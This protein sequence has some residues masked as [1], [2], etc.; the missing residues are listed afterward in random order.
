MMKAKRTVF[1][2]LTFTGVILFIFLIMQPLEILHFKDYIAILFPEGIIG[3][4]ERN[5]LFVIQALMLLI[6]IPV[7][8]LTFIFSWKYRA[9]NT[10][11][12]YDP[13]LE[14]NRLAEYIWWGLPLVMTVIV[15]ALTWVKTSELDPFKPIASPHKEKVIQVIALQWKWLFLYP[16]EKIASLNFFQIPK[17]VPIRFEITADA[18]MNSFWIPDLGGQIYAMPKMKSILYLMANETSDFRGSSAN[19]SGE[20][21]AGMHFMTKASTQE[22]YLKWVESVK[23]SPNSLTRDLYDQLAL[24][25][26]NNPVDTYQLK[27][28]T[29]FEQV[30]MKYMHPSTPKKI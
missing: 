29:L 12:Q 23:Q 10:K 13:D 25:S 24:P 3:L 9:D 27:D 1:L 18:P 22:E 15:A 7:Y 8:L 17:D 14:D 21:F 20:G 26:Q 4:E 5:L 19:L 2:M 11:A 6:V 16:E 28:A 30:I